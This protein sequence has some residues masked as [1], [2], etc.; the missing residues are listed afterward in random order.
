MLDFSS[1]ER[2]RDTAAEL[3]AAC[4]RVRNLAEAERIPEVRLMLDAA[5]NYLGA[6]AQKAHWLQKHVRHHDG[7][8]FKN[9]VFAG[10][11]MLAYA[12]EYTRYKGNLGNTVIEAFEEDQTYLEAVMADVDQQ[13]ND[14]MGTFVELK[15]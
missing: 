13:V 7:S 14:F 8:S 2:F 6:V 15:S 4:R 3:F 12:V 9:A 11:Y 1:E 5:A 10:G